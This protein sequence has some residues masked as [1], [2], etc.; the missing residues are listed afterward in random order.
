MIHSKGIFHTHLV[1][2]DLQRSLRFYS[3]LFGMQDTGFKD[4]D[5]VLSKATADAPSSDPP[6]V[7][8]LER[9]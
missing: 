2:K 4:G 9:A 1:V 8:Y 3:G 7:S 6:W 5:L